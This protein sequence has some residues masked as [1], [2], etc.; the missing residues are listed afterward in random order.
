MLNEGAKT[1]ASLVAPYDAKTQ[2]L[3]LS[4]VKEGGPDEVEEQF[5]NIFESLEAAL[6]EA[7]DE[8]DDDD[9]EKDDDDDEKDDDKKKDDDEKKDDEDD[10][11]TVKEESYLNEGFE[12]LEEKQERENSVKNA[13]RSYIN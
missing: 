13:I 2:E 4:L 3:I 8:K 10:D 1:L 6:S 5:F 9:D 7:D 12:G 11:D